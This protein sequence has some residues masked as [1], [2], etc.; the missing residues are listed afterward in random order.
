MNGELMD[1]EDAKAAARD[2]K[3]TG[4]DETRRCLYIAAVYD[5]REQTIP[6]DLYGTITNALNHHHRDLELGKNVRE[7]W[8]YNI[9]DVIAAITAVLGD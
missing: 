8:M 6:A 4:L 2:S 9:P 3:R 1:I 5:G 7:V